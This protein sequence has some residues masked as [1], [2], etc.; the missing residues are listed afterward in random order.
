MKTKFITLLLFFIVLKTNA[1]AQDKSAIKFS[2]TPAFYDNLDINHKA[3]PHLK[4]SSTFCGEFEVRYYQ[5]IKK[6]YGLN[7]GVGLGLVPYNINFDFEMPETYT[8]YPE[9]YPNARIDLITTEYLNA[10]YLFPISI[11]KSISKSPN[12]KYTIEFGTKLN[13]TVF[14]E[15]E[16]IITNLDINENNQYEDVFIN[17]QE[18]IT[19]N[20]FSYFIKVGLIKGNKIGD[21]FH[22]NLVANMSATDIMKGHY[23]FRHLGYESYGNTSQKLSYIGLELCY[24]LS[25]FQKK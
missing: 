13:K 2:I 17:S 18:S 6:G 20:F 5:P 1:Q 7:I 10:L 24:G 16:I 8:F 25:L 14:N 12:L 3:I 15:W 11:Q 19:N 21:S 4:S 9:E 22:I 23:E